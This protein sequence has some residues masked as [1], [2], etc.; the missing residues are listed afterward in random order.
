MASRLHITA[1]GQTEERYA[2]R[3]LAPYLGNNFQVVTDVRAVKTGR[4]RGRD[5]RGGLLKYQVAKRDILDWMKEEGRNTDVWFTTMF[6]LYA[7]PDDFPDYKHAMTAAD[8][9]ER[10]RR[11]EDAFGQD[12]DHPRFIPYIQLYEFEALIL[13]DPAKLDCQYLEHEQAIENLV[14]LVDGK[15]PEEINDGQ[16][17]APSKRII[18]EIPLYAGQKATAGPLVVEKIA[19]PTLR[20]KCRHFHEWLAKLE[21]LAGA[22]ALG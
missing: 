10:V 22:G 13:A 14:K 8:P 19:L 3:V 15:N 7:L 6:D 12:V 5:Y 16:E 11:L 18:K 20:D 2:N 17:T 9:Y 1:E 21:S 4:K